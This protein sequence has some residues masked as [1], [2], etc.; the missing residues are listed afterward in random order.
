[1][2]LIRN[3]SA[4]T[5]LEALIV[6]FLI[7]F[8]SAVATPNVIKWRNASKLRYAAENAKGDL[9]LAKLK[10]IQ[11]N[12][13]VSVIFSATGYQIF[14]DA[15]QDWNRNSGERS[16]RNRQLPAGISFDLA[17]TS[18]ASSGTKTRFKG[19]GTA[20]NGSA[21]LVNSKGAEKRVKITQYGRV[22]V[23]TIKK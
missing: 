15:N 10:A 21:Y 6:I 11:Q 7:T 2:T 5:L 4:F 3:K 16:V 17:K 20:L 1:M 12:N 13:T 23:E 8:V 19:R 22:T 14:V 9:E 18:F